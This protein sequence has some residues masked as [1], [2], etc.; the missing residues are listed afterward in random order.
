MVKLATHLDSR[1][2]YAVKLMGVPAEGAPTPE[3][4]A[5]RKEIL[6]EIKILATVNHA[7]CLHM[8]ARK[9]CGRTRRAGCG[10][11]LLRAARDSRCWSQRRLRRCS[12]PRAGAGCGVAPEMRALHG[13]AALR[14]AL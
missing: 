5:T 3:S 10:I 9:R 1:Y 13:A 14:S 12:P 11:R 2:E 7:T 6:N 8:K 4:G